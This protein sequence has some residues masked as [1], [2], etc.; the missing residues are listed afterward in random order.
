M[1]RKISVVLLVA[2]VTAS[3]GSA[4]Q[5]NQRFEAKVQQ[6]MADH[7]LPGLAVAHI[8]A[9][10]VVYSNTFGFREVESETRLDQNTVMYG[11]SLTKFMFA[12]FVMQLVNEGKIDLD[13][14]IAQLLPKPLPEYERF[15]DLEGDERW[16][17]LTLRILLSH[18]TGFPNFRFFP[19]TGEFDPDGK[20]EF[21]FDPGY[22]YG[23]SGEGYYIAQ[24]VIEEALNIK[25]RDQFYS[26]FF[27]PLGMTRTD[28][29]WQD[30][31][32]PNFA[33]G[34]TAEGVNEGHNMQSN[35]RAAGSMDTTLSDYS[36][37][38]A[39]Y[40]HGDLLDAETREEQ[41]T[42]VMSITSRHQFPPWDTTP[43]SAHKT[44]G[45][46]AGV[47]IKVFNGLK[48]PGFFHGG[49]NEKTDNLLLCLVETQECVIFLMNTAKGHL[50]FPQLVNELLGDTGLP[51]SWHF[52]GLAE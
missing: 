26:R 39:A 52:S 11:A 3:A 44:V 43:G 13:V 37:W 23:Y 31:F 48:G 7:Q 19:P 34:Y 47:G 1:L 21:L 22:R 12:T 38:V 10:E 32:R 45:L 49:H 18:L 30:R 20:L 15:A 14:S 27:E 50:V 25:T 51:W 40:I 16:K 2:T 28:L 41:L 4:S 36:A 5:N 35:A 42:A 6:K 33:Q 8:K 29:I 9:G 17:Q 46:G 24:L